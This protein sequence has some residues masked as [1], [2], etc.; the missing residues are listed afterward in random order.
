MTGQVWAWL[1]D[2]AHWSGSDGIARR[3]VEH[4]AYCLVAVGVAALIA[5]PLGLLIGHTGRGTV[6]IA[7]TANALRALP[8]LGLVIL[9]VLLVSPHLGGDLAFVGPAIAV[10]VL[11]AIPSILAGTYAGVRQVDP[12]ARDAARGMG[13][14][15]WQ[16]LWQV[17]VPGATALIMSSIRSAMLQVV[18]TATI[19]AYVSLG[20]LGRFLIDGQAVRDYPQML[21]GAVLVAV[22]ALVVDLLL[23]AVQRFATPRGLRVARWRGSR[24]RRRALA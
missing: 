21:G 19:A 7:S 4:V 13:L 24:R 18:A 15:G 9:L 8:T 11:L 2:P 17:E 14:S 12:A 20:G 3:I 16:V 23:I 6:L 22:L 10:L 5:V 1:T